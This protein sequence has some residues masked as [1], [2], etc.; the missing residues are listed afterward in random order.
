M[1]CCRNRWPAEMTPIPRARRRWKLWLLLTALLALA[2]GWVINRQLEPTHFAALAL[3]QAGNLLGLELTSAGQ[4]DYALRP[5]P[6]LRLPDFTARLP[7]AGPVLLHARQ[8]ELSLPWAT[9]IDADAALVITRV[10][11]DEPVLD[12]AIMRRWLATQPTT[13]TIEL[14][15]FTHGLRIQDGTLHDTGWR[16]Q[17]WS[18]AL[19]SLQPGKP[20]TVIT[21][22]RVLMAEQQIEFDG[23]ASVSSASRDSDL[24]LAVRGHWQT[25]ER[26]LPYRLALQGRFHSDEAAHTLHLSQLA[27]DSESPLPDF[28]GQL[29]AGLSTA[30]ADDQLRL[31]LSG[32]LA[33]WPSDWPALPAPVSQSASPLHLHAEYQGADDFS[34]ATRLAL[35][36]DDTTVDSTLHWPVLKAWLD[37]PNAAPLPPIALTVRSP[38][39]ELDGARMEGVTVE[40][41]APAEAKP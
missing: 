32:E 17:G 7:G 19:A 39:I 27:L 3:G 6:R 5:E 22:G 40:L 25:P 2:C 29:D 12:L 31:S 30:V 33:A 28:T 14:P 15:T 34:G 36:R 24:A 4:P 20:A 10:S 11:L 9:L 23:E 26:T 38:R 8:L 16:L 13:P 35:Q 37:N 18:L 1:P 41:D 21:R